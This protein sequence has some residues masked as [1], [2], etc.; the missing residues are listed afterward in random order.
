[1]LNHRI[2]NPFLRSE[3]DG[4]ILWTGPLIRSISAVHDGRKPPR[5]N[6]TLDGVLRGVGEV[7]CY[8]VHD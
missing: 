5:R 2:S 3:G 8:I 4:P 1:M 6:S 7:F